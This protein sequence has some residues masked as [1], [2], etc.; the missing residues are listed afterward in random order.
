MSAQI[1]LN[2]I[3]AEVALCDRDRRVARSV[4]LGSMNEV[5]LKQTRL[6]VSFSWAVVL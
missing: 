4:H 3:S 2:I 1:V 6:Q 5:H